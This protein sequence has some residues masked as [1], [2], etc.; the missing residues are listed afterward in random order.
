MYTV[1]KEV[2]IGNEV[3]VNWLNL[4]AINI[5]LQFYFKI[6][7]DQL[8]ASIEEISFGLSVESNN[9]LVSVKKK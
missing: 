2:T 4:S 6:Q 9:F 1:T 8:I 7:S 5:K 3:E